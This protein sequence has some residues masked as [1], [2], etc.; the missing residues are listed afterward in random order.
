MTLGSAVRK[1]IQILIYSTHKK[2][3]NNNKKFKLNLKN[4]L[5]KV[6]ILS[7]KMAGNN[8]S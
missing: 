2:I 7:Q 6:G 5:K 4:D 3:N 1:R 8:V